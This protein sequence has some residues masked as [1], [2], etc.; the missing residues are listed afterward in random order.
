MM[1]KVIF[2][3]AIEHANIDI[4]GSKVYKAFSVIQ[5]ATA[6]LSLNTRR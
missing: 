5:S 6:P 4:F 3:F 2:H 1:L